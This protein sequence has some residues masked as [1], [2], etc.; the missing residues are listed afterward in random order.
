[1]SLTWQCASL[2]FVRKIALLSR[3][4]VKATK[5]AKLPKVP[6]YL[7]SQRIKLPSY[8]SYQA[9]HSC[10]ATQTCQATIAAK[11]PKLVSY[12][13]CQATEAIKPPKPPTMSTAIK[14]AKLLKLPS[15]SSYQATQ[16]TKN[17]NIY[18]SY[19]RC[20]AIH[21]KPSNTSKSSKPL[22]LSTPPKPFQ[23]Y[24]AHFSGSRYEGGVDRSDDVTEEKGVPLASA[25]SFAG[26]VL[27]EPDVSP[28]G[29]KRGKT[30]SPSSSALPFRAFRG[31]FE[32]KL[33]G[34]RLGSFSRSKEVIQLPLRK[35][36]LHRTDDDIVLL[37]R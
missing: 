21:Q 27:S 19:Q 1:M 24:S 35:S 5:V 15:Y 28:G 11:L 8:R 29:G 17:V 18:R 3:R 16:A 7:S 37:V 22:K 32:P 6:S 9:T 13:S 10:Q 31:H 36:Q 30:L 20:I 26:H 4:A 34:I 12:H 23:S 14:A 25:F 2:R 33:L